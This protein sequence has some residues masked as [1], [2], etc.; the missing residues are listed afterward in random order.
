MRYLALS[1]L[2]LALASCATTAPV[3]SS[4]APSSHIASNDQEYLDP[5]AILSGATTPIPVAAPRKVSP[6]APAVEDPSTRGHYVAGG[7]YKPGV[8]DSIAGITVDAHLIPEPEVEDLPR[9]RYGNKPV[10]AVLGKQY[11]VM[12]DTH[13]Y[14]E[15]GTASYYGKKFHGR[16]TSAQ[17]VYD[18]YAFSAAHK[19]LPIPSFARVTNLENGQSV[20]V[21][22]N[23][24]GPFHEGRVIDLSLATAT[25]LGIVQ[26]GTGRVRV[27]ALQP[28]VRQY[29]HTRSS[30]T[31]LTPA[32]P[33]QTT[34]SSSSA[35]APSSAASQLAI[36]FAPVD[37]PP[38]ATTEAPVPGVPSSIYMPE[39][40]VQ[41]KAHSTTYTQQ[42][43]AE[44]NSE[45]GYTIATG[46]PSTT[47][48][49]APN[50]PTAVTTAPG[51][52]PAEV[53]TPQVAAYD[54]GQF[55]PEAARFS[56]MQDGKRMSADEFD[57]WLKTQ[58][59]SIA[60]GAP[61]SVEQEPLQATST[62]VVHQ[63]VAIA[64]LPAP[65][66]QPMLG[67]AK[68][69]VFVPSTGDVVPATDETVTDVSA[70]IARPGD[71]E[72]Q[73]ASFA[74][75]TNA[76]DAMNKLLQA[77]ING[78]RL[79]DGYSAAGARIWR[80][81]VGPVAQADSGAMIERIKSLGLGQA[82]R[83]LK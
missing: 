60:T 15:E 68:S 11:R 22:V 18:M 26:R 65:S 20:V 16:M 51:I 37:P 62:A 35:M 30:S 1:A 44:S 41:P 19:T 55:R 39:P 17:E 32:A 57:A 10:Y 66:E 28:T 33:A 34:P 45:R 2:S 5:A 67:E 47:T 27:E 80:L 40:M 77:G 12:D 53:S 74:S 64:D 13:G 56:L 46:V 21:R 38:A 36:H 7:L 76:N 24:R 23:D 6:Y 71:V 48:A 54:N 31:P 79:V 78:A 49:S 83:V 75:Q 9:S 42:D 8:R 61:R 82:Q 73:V 63:A 70:P 58:K 59:I 43:V 81:R 25:K 4:K 52:A 50:A 72:L 3:T 14:V 69:V 29:A